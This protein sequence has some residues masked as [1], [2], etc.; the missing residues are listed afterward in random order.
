MINFNSTCLL[1][2][3]FYRSIEQTGLSGFKDTV[4]CS[5]TLGGNDKYHGFLKVE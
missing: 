1:V 2:W 3:Y 4:C 5:Q